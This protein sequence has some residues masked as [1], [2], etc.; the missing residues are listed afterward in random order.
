MAFLELNDVQKSYGEHPVLRGIDL[1]VEQHQV[2]CLIGA[3]G[4][5]KST[6]L[7]T[8]NGLEE[9]QGGEIRLDGDI[10]SGEG[11]DL[12]GLRTRIGIVFQS[13]NLF[14]HMTVRENVTL[15][16]RRVLGVSKADAD[17]FAMR[18]LRRVGLD[19]KADAY[20][21]QLSGGQQQRV[22][23]VRAVAM[24]TDVLLL[25]EITSALDPELVAEVL[26]IVKDLAAEGLTILMATHEMSF[27][28]EVADSVAFLH[29]GR[30]LEQGPPEQ[31]FTSPREERT[32][33]FLGQI[34]AAGRL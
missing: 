11:V 34:I 10:V 9:I 33:A 24:D 2:V 27:A 12:N 18:L 3:S 16:P 14:P 13:F 25:D 20:P 5:G 28:R 6:L 21:D 17:D 29:E 8:I 26:N 4:C 19:H 31:I 1:H 7:R 30:V 22:A 15:A 32:R 23:I